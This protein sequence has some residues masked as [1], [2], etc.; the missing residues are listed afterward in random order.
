MVG[1]SCQE[2]ADMVG[3]LGVS[4]AEKAR[5]GPWAHLPRVRTWEGHRGGA[6][7]ADTVDVGT[8]QRE[9][10]LAREAACE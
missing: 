2:G 7:P 3:V 10:Q 1:M 6:K 5:L 9:G 4:V 8:G